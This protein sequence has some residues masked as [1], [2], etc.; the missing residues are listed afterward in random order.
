MISSPSYF[1]NFILN[2]EMLSSKFSSTITRHKT[3]YPAINP[4]SIRLSAKGKVVLI[5]GGGQGI[6]LSIALAFSKASASH[7][8]II[9]RNQITLT[10][11]QS[12]I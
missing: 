3:S 5:T 2:F 4:S 6:G 7:I 1:F 10:A 12:T 11:A 9:G 8:V